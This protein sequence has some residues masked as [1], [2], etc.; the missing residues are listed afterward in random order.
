MI[1]W[2]PATRDPAR[3]ER[4]MKMLIKKIDPHAQGVDGTGGDGGRDS[5]VPTRYVA[6][7]GMWIYEVKSFT[8]RMTGS[9]D[10]WCIDWL[11]DQFNQ[12]EGLRRFLEGDEYQVS[13]RLAELNMEPFSTCAGG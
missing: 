5:Y 10:R 3:F 7:D 9:L 2:A 6:G 12:D 11:D 1:H 4:A 8:G 13:Q